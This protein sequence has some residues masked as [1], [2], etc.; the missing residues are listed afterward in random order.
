MH[1]LAHTWD[2]L[3]RFH[4]VHHSAPRLY[5]LN[6]V[7]FHPIDLAISTYAPFVPLVTLGADARVLALFVLVSAVHG[8]FQHANLPIRC[9]PLNWFFS[10]AELHRW[11][12]SRALEEANTNFGQNLIVWDI[13]H[14]TRFLPKD[15]E[16]P[17]ETGIAGMPAFPMSY[18]AQLASPFTWSR[19]KRDNEAALST[20]DAA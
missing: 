15:R 5:F 1:R 12:H 2:F 13:I 4:A 11:H 8:L 20:S 16:P 19:I 6:A 14:G 3:W 18:L 7:R 17:E 9:G 10:M